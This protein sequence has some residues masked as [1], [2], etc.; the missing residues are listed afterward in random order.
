VSP[1][2]IRAKIQAALPDAEVTL[3]DLTGT[4]DHWKARI[5]SRSFDGLTLMQRHRLINRALASEL[6]G[7]IHALTMDT[8]T[9]EEAA[10][11]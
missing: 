1:D 4:K 11:H 6:L 9:P 10:A 7:P 8:L 3:E 5:V 2:D